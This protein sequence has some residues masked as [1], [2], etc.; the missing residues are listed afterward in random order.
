L[1]KIQEPIIFQDEVEEEPLGSNDDIS[2]EDPS[3]LFNTENVI[4]IA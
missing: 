2:E 4:F 1:Q 3:E